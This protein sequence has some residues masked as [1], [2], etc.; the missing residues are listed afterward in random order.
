MGPNRGG[1]KN[2]GVRLGGGVAFLSSTPL[3]ALAAD[4]A[5]DNGRLIVLSALASGAVALAIAASLWALAEQRGA[6]RLRRIL[7]NAGARNRTALGERDA[8]LSAARESL[9]V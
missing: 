8:L 3:P 4:P 2:W 1:L 5:F 7:R 9:V 6:Q